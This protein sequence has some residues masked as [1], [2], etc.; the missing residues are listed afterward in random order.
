MRRLSSF[1]LPVC[2]E[3]CTF[4]IANIIQV[5]HSSVHY[6][7]TA[8]VSLS[9]FRIPYVAAMV[10]VGVLAALINVA[11]LI[12][13]ALADRGIELIVRRFAASRLRR[14]H[15]V[16]VVHDSDT[17]L[18][19]IPRSIFKFHKNPGKHPSSSSP[20]FFFFFIFYHFT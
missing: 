3:T 2:I 20:S 7:S 9:N 4:F 15:R 17:W 5:P 12:L 11:V 10:S 8:C 13:V 1:F 19:N 16:P 18:P 6:R 14:F